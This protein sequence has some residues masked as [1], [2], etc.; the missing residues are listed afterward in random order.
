MHIFTMWLFHLLE[1][2]KRVGLQQSGQ[3]GLIF[4]NTLNIHPL[5]QISRFR[6]IGLKANVGLSV[7]LYIHNIYLQMITYVRSKQRDK[8]SLTKFF[9]LYFVPDYLSAIILYSHYLLIIKSYLYIYLFIHYF[10]SLTCCI[11]LNKN[12]I[13]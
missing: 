13:K 12:I 3:K 1:E 2:D 4:L 8:I 5:P 7:V 11:H 6:P 10:L 9:N